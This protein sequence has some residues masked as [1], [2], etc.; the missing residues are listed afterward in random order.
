MN[1]LN[2]ADYDAFDVALKGFAQGASTSRGYFNRAVEELSAVV[3]QLPTG[4][5]NDDGPG[6][7]VLVA[8]QTSLEA[9]PTLCRSV[10][11]ILTEGLDSALIP[12]AE[13][14][15]D[16]CHRAFRELSLFMASLKVVTAVELATFPGTSAS[17]NLSKSKN[18]ANLRALRDLLMPLVLHT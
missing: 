9:T 10:L 11:E 17:D 12:D 13:L 6:G 5:I 7:V 4:P 18:F 16:D 2:K 14:G 3:S 15:A 8:N 1:S